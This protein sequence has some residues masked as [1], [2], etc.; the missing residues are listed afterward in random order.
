MVAINA[1]NYREFEGETAFKCGG[2]GKDVRR[3][4][5]KYVSD[6]N[7]T[8]SYLKARL[9]MGLLQCPACQK[10]QSRHDRRH[11]TT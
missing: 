8:G 7:P 3:E 2:C 1:W 5:K 4:S 10:R 6:R 11:H 9:V